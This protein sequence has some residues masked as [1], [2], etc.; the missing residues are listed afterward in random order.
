[1]L[2]LAPVAGDVVGDRVAEQQAERRGRD[3]EADRAQ[4]DRDVERVEGVGV[5]VEPE[6]V[7]GAAEVVGEAERE[8]QDEADRD[9]EE[10]DSQT[11]PGSRKRDQKPFE[12]NVGLDLG[13]VW[14][15]SARSSAVVEPVLQPAVA[16]LPRG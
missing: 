13:P 5:V 14:F 11:P 2:A 7:D 12:L 6:R 9:D 10:Q 15:Q 3:R 8:R 4:Q 16:E 1:M